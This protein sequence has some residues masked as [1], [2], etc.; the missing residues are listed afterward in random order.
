MLL[1]HPAFYIICIAFI[2]GCQN[3]D[4]A[5]VSGRVTLDGKPL[6]EGLVTFLPAPET[7]GPEFSGNV[8]NGEYRVTQSV[9]PGA[10]SVKVRSWQ[11]TGRIVESP[12]GGNTD[13]IIDIIPKRYGSPESELTAELNS[14]PNWIH[15]TLN[16]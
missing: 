1:I 2:A 8:S 3:A 9:L 15:F 10:Y 11:K 14:G 6:S 4:L 12:Y 5:E 7:A 13:E 16:Q